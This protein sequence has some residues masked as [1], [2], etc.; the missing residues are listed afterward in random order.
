MG[1]DWHSSGKDFTLTLWGHGFDPWSGE[2]R[3]CMP[4]GKAKKKKE[5]KFIRNLGFERENRNKTGKLI[6]IWNIYINI[7]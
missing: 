4:C 3:F 2:L 5:K 7:K 1:L 6:A